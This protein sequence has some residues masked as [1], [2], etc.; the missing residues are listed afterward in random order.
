MAT[1]CSE[2]S[3]GLRQ[4]IRLLRQSGLSGK[5]AE[6]PCWRAEQDVCVQQVA[7]PENWWQQN[8]KAHGDMQHATSEDT[9]HIIGKGFAEKA[10][11]VGH[12]SEGETTVRPPHCSQGGHSVERN[13]SLQKTLFG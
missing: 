1:D 2:R 5:D 6:P 3:H 13:T 12:P 9:W 10:A 11:N 4:N 8:V 7:A